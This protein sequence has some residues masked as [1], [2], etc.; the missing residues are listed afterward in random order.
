MAKKKIEKV[1]WYNDAQIITGLILSTV[2]LIVL[3]SQS[4]ANGEFSFALFSSVINHNSI[5]LLVFI[6]FLL[7]Q[8]HFGKKYFN[9]LNAFLIFIYIITTFTS[10]LTL[11]QSLDL[12]TVFTFI[13]NFI[14]LVYFIHTFLR[15]TRFWEELHL[16][17]SP[18][19]ELTNEG[20]Y[21]AIVIISVL[22]L[23]VNLINTVAISGVVLSVLDTVYFML[24]GR[25]AYLYW[26]YLD[27]KK[28]DNEN[29][30]NLDD[31]KVKVQEVLDKTDVD[32]IIVDSIKD[33]KGVFTKEKEEEEEVIEPPK[34]T[35]RRTTKK[36]E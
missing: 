33:V 27:K 4:F 1:A 36:G 25:Y 21:Y 20:V 13:L 34:R 15:G 12:T 7:I 3:C 32:E 18:F 29:E 35:T 9:Y 6:Y 5:Y 23:A 28:I 10:F 11:T 8:I 24:L 30:G 16:S 31:V 19:H 17:S 14:F 26:E 2:I 22:L